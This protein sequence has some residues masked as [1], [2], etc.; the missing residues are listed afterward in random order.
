[1]HIL[2]GCRAHWLEQKM[3]N[4]G[5]RQETRGVKR[6]DLRKRWVFKKFLFC[7]EV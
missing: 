4:E 1:M 3:R 2:T 7:I 5:E 6:L